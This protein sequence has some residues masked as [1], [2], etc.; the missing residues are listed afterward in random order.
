MVG[1]A[2]IALHDFHPDRGSQY[3]SGEFGRTP[4][5]RGFVASMSRK[6]TCWEGAMFCD[7]RR[8]S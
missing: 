1:F 4:A 2:G 6:G 5:A 3:A 8:K 7:M